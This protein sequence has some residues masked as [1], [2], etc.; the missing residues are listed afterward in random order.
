ML[1]G[2]VP[3]YSFLLE[4]SWLSS[5]RT[6]Q[7]QPL[8]SLSLCQVF[9][10]SREK[11]AGGF[12]CR[13][14]VG[15]RGGGGEGGRTKKRIFRCNFDH[16]PTPEGFGVGLDFPRVMELDWMLPYRGPFLT[17][18]SLSACIALS[19]PALADMKGQV[20]VGNP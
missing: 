15:G 14:R 3:S 18:V 1:A 6:A 5:V 9:R 19:S 13:F 7:R 17:P 12:R 2:T 11:D 4:V 16:P 10:T 20:T 8:G